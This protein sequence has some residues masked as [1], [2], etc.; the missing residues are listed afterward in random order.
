[1][2]I[3]LFRQIHQPHWTLMP[4]SFQKKFML[5]FHQKMH[6]SGYVEERCEIQLDTHCAC[7]TF[8][9][10]YFFVSASVVLCI[11]S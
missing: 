4:R 2:K 3:Q 5:S 11:I 6:N 7:C 10:R 8:S 1:M 9:C